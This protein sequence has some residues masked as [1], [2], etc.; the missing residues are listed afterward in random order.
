MWHAVCIK[1]H[2]NTSKVVTIPHQLLGSTM[3]FFDPT[4]GNEGGSCYAFLLAQ[5]RHFNKSGTDFNG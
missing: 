2:A 3:H 4:Q 5:T 1:M